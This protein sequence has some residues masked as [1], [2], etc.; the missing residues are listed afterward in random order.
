MSEENDKYDD[1]TYVKVIIVGDSGAGKTS[2]IK[3]YIEKKFDNNTSAT[4]T[5]ITS[6][7]KYS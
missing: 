3:R 2:I 5:A 7:K 1:S 4:I 6:N